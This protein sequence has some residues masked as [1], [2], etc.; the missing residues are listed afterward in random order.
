VRRTF[1]GALQTAPVAQQVLALVT[2]LHR[3]EHE[4]T[5]QKLFGQAK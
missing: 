5:K 1:I 3:V 4:A 2:S